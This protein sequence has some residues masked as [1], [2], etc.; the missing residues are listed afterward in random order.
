[1][2]PNR[3]VWGLKV[4]M[5]AWAAISAAAVL[6]ALPT[7]V[8][9]ASADVAQADTTAP[10]AQADT[11][12]WGG[13][14]LGVMLWLSVAVIAVIVALVALRHSRSQLPPGDA[15]RVAG[16]S[17]AEIHAATTRSAAVTPAGR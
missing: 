17:L 5:R 1:M 15:G 8:G 4:M 7:A 10:V 13:A 14:E 16:T 9:R 11:A 12:S 2:D 6:V 3:D